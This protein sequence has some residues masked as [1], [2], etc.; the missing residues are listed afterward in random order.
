MFGA[1]AGRCQSHRAAAGGSICGRRIAHP[2]I[3]GGRRPV[4]QLADPANYLANRA[5]ASAIMDVS[6][7]SI[8]TGEAA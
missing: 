1:A 2:S 3:A 7:T 5:Q 8:S 6:K 4:A